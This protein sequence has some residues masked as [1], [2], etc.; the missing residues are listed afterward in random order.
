[1]E[2]YGASIDMMVCEHGHIHVTMKPH[3][4]DCPAL[5]IIL[6]PNDA[7]EMAVKL[8]EAANEVSPCQ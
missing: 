6:E 5:G 3:E 8:L 2:I 7:R 4:I 1:M